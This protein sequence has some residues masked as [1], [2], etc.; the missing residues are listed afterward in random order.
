MTFLF[1]QP[2]QL[3]FRHDVDDA[4]LFLP[5]EPIVG[6]TVASD[7]ARNCPAVSDKKVADFV[8]V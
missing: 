8:F 2:P 5:V 1:H 4:E 7:V 6:S 3:G